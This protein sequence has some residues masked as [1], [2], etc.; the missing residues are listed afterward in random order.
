MDELDRA[1]YEFL[2][3]LNIAGHDASII[4]R[5]I[6]WG[7]IPGVLCEEWMFGEFNASS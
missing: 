3:I 1:C 2:A 5:G 6:H 4:W 7:V